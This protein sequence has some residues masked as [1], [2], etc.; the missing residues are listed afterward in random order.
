MYHS[1][2][3]TSPN[4]NYLKE[5]GGNIARAGVLELFTHLK[6][7]GWLPGSLV[8][9]RRSLIVGAGVLELSLLPLLLGLVFLHPV[10][11]ILQL[12]PHL[13]IN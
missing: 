8:S 1:G 4:Y 13:R 9:L 2:Y 3:A 7:G 5:G 11:V 12:D 6:D 10:Q